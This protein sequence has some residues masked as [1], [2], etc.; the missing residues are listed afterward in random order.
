VRAARAA[1]DRAR[2]RMA[3]ILVLG[4]CAALALLLARQLLA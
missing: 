4:E 2:A 3:L 1:P